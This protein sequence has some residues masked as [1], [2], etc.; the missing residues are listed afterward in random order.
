MLLLNK[1]FVRSSSQKY[2]DWFNIKCIAFKSK[3][4]Y[5]YFLNSRVPRLKQLSLFIIERLNNEL[6]VKV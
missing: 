2:R 6:F 1:V 3:T 5:A 4:F